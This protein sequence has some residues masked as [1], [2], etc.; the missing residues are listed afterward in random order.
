MELRDILNRIH[1]LPDLSADKILTVAREVS[2]KKNTSFIVSDTVCTDIFLIKTGIVRA[3]IFGNG[4]E[5]TFWIGEEGSVALSMQGY[6]NGRRGYENIA[7][8][9]DTEAYRVPG[10]YLH[11]LYA[12]DLHIANWGRLFAESEILRAE[13]NLIPQLFTTGRERYEALLEESPHLL[14]RVPL[15]ILSSYLGL[16]P[17]SLSR[18]RRKISSGNNKNHI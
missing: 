9:E 3:Y 12:T 10:A 5:I 1:P 18:V 8:V 17:V 4:R 7:T 11:E 2:I 13:K 6:I 16:T 15:E 14:N